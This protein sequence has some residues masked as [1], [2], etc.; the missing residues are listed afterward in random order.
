MYLKHKHNQFNDAIQFITYS[1]NCSG[2][3]ACEWW[4]ASCP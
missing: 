1:F 3:I 4:P 2:K